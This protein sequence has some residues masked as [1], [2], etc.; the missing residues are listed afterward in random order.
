MVVTLTISKKIFVSF[1]KG[2]RKTLSYFVYINFLIIVPGLDGEEHLG[3]T[4]RYCVQPAH[5]YPIWTIQSLI[6]STRLVHCKGKV[7]VKTIGQNEWNNSIH[8]LKKIYINI[9]ILLVREK[10]STRNRVIF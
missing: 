4:Q 6:D 7:L 8:Y 10:F 3:Q 5:H 9:I 2:K 1:S